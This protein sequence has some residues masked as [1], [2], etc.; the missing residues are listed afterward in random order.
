[1]ASKYLRLV[2]LITILLYGT[3]CC[4]KKKDPKPTYYI[5]QEFKDY[6]DF[7]EGSYWIYERESDKTIDS[8]YL[9]QRAERIND[10]K[11][12]SYNFEEYSYQLFTSFYNDT[13]LNI[14][15]ALRGGITSST[16]YYLQFYH[17]AFLIFFSNAS[18]GDSIDLTESMKAK[19]NYYYDSL[20][21]SGKYYYQVK[22]FEILIYQGEILPRKIYHSPNIGIIK[23]ED[24]NGSIWQIKRYNVNK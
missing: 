1:M 5:D 12:L 2:L 13:L 8:L 24:F 18:P 9:F 20:Q 14:G 7:K 10:S 23:K 11:R 15:V 22:E 6:C 19:Y 3:F 17:A 16:Q 4:N 21:V